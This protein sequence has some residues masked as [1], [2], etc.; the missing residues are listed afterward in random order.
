MDVLNR[1]ARQF[2]ELYSRMTLSQRGT[3]VVVPAL[4]IGAFAMLLWSRPGA[5]YSALSWGKVFS[6]EELMTT[7]QALIQAGLT[8]FRREGQRLMVPTADLD[9]YTAAMVE[10]DAIP[11]DMGSELIKNFETLGPFSTDR[12]RQEMKDA[13]LL[14]ELQRVIMTVPDIERARVG[15]AGSGRPNSWSRKNRVTANVTVQPRA[16]RELSQRLVASLRAV[17]ASMVPD[18][19]P[20]DVTIFDSRNGISYTGESADDPFNSGL[21]NRIRELTGQ[22]EQ[23]IQKDL[24]YIPDVGVTVH[25]DV[26]NLKS[27]VTRN[28]IVDPKKTAPLYSSDFKTTDNMQQRPPRGEAGLRAN[29]PGALTAA[30][31][32]ERTRQLDEKSNSA[33]NGLSFE[34]TEKELIAAMPK[35]VQVSVKIPR[36]YYREIADQ[37]TAAG[38]KDPARTDAAQIEQDVL[39]SVQKSVAR[40]IPAG[41]PVDA[42]TVTSF[43]RVATD[44]GDAPIVWS[45]RITELVRQWGG[46]AGMVLLSLAALVLLRRQ[47]KSLPAESGSFADAAGLTAGRAIPG[48]TGV[49]AAPVP[50]EEI[51][52]KDLPKREVIQNLVRDNPEMTANVINKWLQAAK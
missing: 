39:A 35:A 26:E 34:V 48:M 1:I 36:D 50:P 9:Q 30:A 32:P 5:S 20:S 10:S 27:S 8:D 25:V 37:R 44:A 38:D 45:E 47:M 3:L 11:A 24:S 17:V 19:K 31:A 42:V 16:G 51:V 18:L 40:L 22:Y 6:T 2:Q 33:I 12:Q 43:E 49:V 46:P 29:Q 52:L 21:L 13:L 23:Q 4:V 28:Q 7:E 14:K 41:S 15:I